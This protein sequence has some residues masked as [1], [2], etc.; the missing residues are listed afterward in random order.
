MTL[1]GAR[2]RLGLLGLGA[3]MMAL[4]PATALA[5][6]PTDAQYSSSLQQISSGGG[7]PP[8]TTSSAASNAASGLPFTGLDVALLAAV[9]AGLLIAGLLLWRH[10]PTEST[11]A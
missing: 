10:R 6:A 11:G 5:A 4:V 7:D 9:A 3:V 1:A 8:S 2:R